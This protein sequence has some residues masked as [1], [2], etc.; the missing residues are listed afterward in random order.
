VN[1]EQTKKAWRS[2]GISLVL[3]LLLTLVLY[4]HT[5]L[6]LTGKWNQLDIGE[7][8]HGYLVL[9]ISAY[10]IVNNRRALLNLA[11][12]LE[13]R[14]LFGVAAASMLW[15]V[16]ALVNVEMVQS[17][18]LLFLVLFIVWAALGNQ[19]IR[20]LAF[21]V[22]FIGFAI[23]I[24]FP[25]SPILQ[26]LTADVVFGMIRLI[27]VPAMR[28]DNMIMLP[29]GTLSVEEACS[30]L[31]YLLAALTLGT[32]YAYMNYSSLRSRIIV[33]LIAAGAA[34]LVNMVRVFIVVYLAYTTEMQHPLVDDHLSLGWYLFGGLVVILLV[35]DA[36]LNRGGALP[37]SDV[38]SVIDEASP[39]VRKKPL[40]YYLVFVAGVSI[41]VAV[42]PAVV[43]KVSHQ[44]FDEMVSSA[45]DLPGDSC[46]YITG[47]SIRAYPIKRI[48]MRSFFMSAITRCNSRVKS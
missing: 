27:S 17:V 10:L 42:A 14:A 3:L 1:S 18:G 5:V 36:R 11:P 7:Y 24:W 13:Y 22:L 40:R 46:Q 29:A 32:L 33:V 45:I 31:R 35:V 6:Y 41:T 4:Q 9:A 39:D 21:P 12:C 16:A 8:A 26:N 47:R 30:G 43:Y 37:E 28:Q 2:A 25:L 48:M 15:M 19:I 44:S 23:P 20:V 34:I 38:V